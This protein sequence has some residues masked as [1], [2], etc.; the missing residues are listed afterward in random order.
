[1]T[2]LTRRSVLKMLG[3][4]AMAASAPLGLSSRA[5]ASERDKE[6]NILCWEGYN[7]AEVLDPYR[8]LRGAKVSAES[9]SYNG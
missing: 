2:E 8:K 6:L 3:A 1:M 7:S 5:F 4:S 9:A